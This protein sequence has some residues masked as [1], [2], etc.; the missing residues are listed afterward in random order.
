MFNKSTRKKNTRAKGELPLQSYFQGKWLEFKPK[1]IFIDRR[2][3]K[4]TKAKANAR[5]KPIFIIKARTLSQT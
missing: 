1:P 5:Y 3:I 2:S 4:A